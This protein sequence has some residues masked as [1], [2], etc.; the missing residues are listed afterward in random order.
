MANE[1]ASIVQRVWNY[2]NVLRDDGMSY[3]DYVEQLTYLLFLKMVCEREQLPIATSSP[4][5]ASRIPAG[6]DWKSLLSLSGADLEEHYRKILET[7][8]KSEGMLGIIF[9]KAQNKIQN[10]ALLQRL[11]IDLI[12]RET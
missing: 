4:A 2:C 9:R 8:G 5:S 1:S 7:L 11:I 10:P 6:Y 12:D 3:G